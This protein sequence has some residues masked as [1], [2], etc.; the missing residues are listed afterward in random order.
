MN[1]HTLHSDTHTSHSTS[2]TS[3]SSNIISDGGGSYWV[4]GTAR[5]NKKEKVYS[6]IDELL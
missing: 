5:Y 3:G 6:L 4:A 2:S 1:I